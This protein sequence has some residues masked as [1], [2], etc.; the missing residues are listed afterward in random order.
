MAFKAYELQELIFLCQSNVDGLHNLHSIWP[1]TH[2]FILLLGWSVY[3]ETELV[4]MVYYFIDCLFQSMLEI[5]AND[6]VLIARW[7]QLRETGTNRKKWLEM[8]IQFVFL[9]VL[10]YATW[11]MSDHWSLGTLKWWWTG[12]QQYS[13]R[14]KSWKLW[15]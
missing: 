1:T 12:I 15:L 11:T 4:H 13:N 9:G 14:S 3:Q 8:F 10:S 2:I 5:K 6:C 7:L